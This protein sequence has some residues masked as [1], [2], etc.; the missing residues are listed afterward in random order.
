MKVCYSIKDNGK[1]HMVCLFFY[2]YFLEPVTPREFM[3]T[4]AFPDNNAMITTL[5]WI[6]P[7]GPTVDY[8]RISV[9]P[10]P[11]SH[12][13]ST[14]VLSP[15]WTVALELGTSYV[16]NLTAINCVGESGPVT[17]NTGT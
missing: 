11:P 15:P 8:Y 1:L 9:I 5:A 10:V 4:G 6:Q 12:P 14:I 16:I 13:G 3:I 2:A 7:L 17:K